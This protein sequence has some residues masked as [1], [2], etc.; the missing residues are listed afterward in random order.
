[1]I[2]I[3]KKELLT[4]FYSARNLIM[5]SLCIII[6]IAA[7]VT[8]YLNYDYERQLYDH[9]ISYQSE[10]LGDTADYEYMTVYISREPS[11][12]SIFNSGPAVFLGRNA[13]IHP[14][15]LRAFIQSP[16]AEDPVLA[17]FGSFDITFVVTWLFSLLAFMLSYDSFSGEK[18]QG[19]LK[20][21]QANSIGRVRHA[22]GTILGRLLSTLAMVTVSLLAG[23]TVMMLIFPVRFNGDE[24][25]LL[26]LTA[27]FYLLLTSLCSLAGSA[28]SCFTHTRQSSLLLSLLTWII[29][30]FVVPS[31]ASNVASGLA[32]PMLRQ[33]FQARYNS[34]MEDN[35]YRVDWRLRDYLK[36]NPTTMEEWSQYNPFDLVESE[37]TREQLGE[38]INLWNEFFL[39]RQQTLEIYKFVS[40]FSPV[41]LTQQAIDTIAGSG[42][43]REFELNKALLRYSEELREYIWGKVLNPV[44]DSGQGREMNFNRNEEGIF[45]A[46]INED[47]SPPKLDFSDMPRFTAPAV[48]PGRAVPAVLY[49]FLIL[50]AM[51]SLALLV[52]LLVFRRYD[53]R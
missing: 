5:L 16:A 8:G 30:I 11:R 20:L 25:G 39:R 4:V 32:Q 2:T 40:P 3:I 49:N 51:F 26:G 50:L 44:E 35:K 27:V 48:S 28:I 13:Y 19:T 53:V 22:T 43:E 14:P 17:M 52:S 34:I 46:S 45:T 10:R 47:Y 12:L 36:K 6:T 7:M 21:V 41:S 33:E 37:I 38:I 1:M 29:I 42:Y 24:W 31:I 9:T 23:L 15:R 18:E